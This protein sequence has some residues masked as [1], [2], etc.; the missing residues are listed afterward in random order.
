MS[1]F[2]K[3]R[4]VQPPAGVEELDPA[5]L[6]PGFR[7]GGAHCGLKG[8]GKTDV[9]LIVCDAEG[10][11]SAILLTRNASAAAPV[12]VCRKRCERGAIRAAVVNAGNANAETGE[13]GYADAVAMCDAA[14]EALG[15]RPETVAVAETGVI[16]VP[17]P[18]DAVL[19]GIGEAAGNLKP[20][21]GA[22]FSDAILTTDRWPKR[23]TLSAGGVTL[24][25]QAKGGGMIQ[26][27][28]A[29]MLCFVQTDAVV[30]DP[31]S[32]LRAASDASF[33]RITVDGQMSTNDTVLL[34]ATGVSGKPLPEGLLE[35]VLLQLALEVVADGEGSS[36][37]GRIRVNGAASQAEAERV[38]RAIA[39]S[40]L[41]K[42][43]LFGR[44]QNWGRIAQAAGMALAGEDLEEIGAENIDNDEL[45]ADIAEAEIGLRLDRGAHSAYVW[46]SDLGYEYVRINAEYTT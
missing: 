21:G 43:A 2:F 24:S 25:A 7:A 41:V 46:F 13:Q 31:D 1:G 6:A 10:V 16:G 30:E 12:R 8:G 11:S 40:P 27:N 9:G 36:R 32:A 33:E 26:P 35:A 29:T 22:V 28:M 18:I 42:T 45:G 17:L 34:Q 23:C 37:V 44:D 3:S 19:G 14:A 4:W 39:N 20:D 15:L 38:A 5:Q